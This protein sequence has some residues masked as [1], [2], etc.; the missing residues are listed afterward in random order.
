MPDSMH[1]L[2][3]AEAHVL[4]RY[5]VMTIPKATLRDLQHGSAEKRTMALDLA[6]DVVRGHFQRARHEIYR[7]QPIADHGS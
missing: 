2:T 6:T 7:P 5:A 3:D 1:K 4:I